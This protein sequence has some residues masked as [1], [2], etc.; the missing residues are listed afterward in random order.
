MR[1][2]LLTAKAQAPRPS[3]GWAEGAHT[4]F[5]LSLNLNQRPG[6]LEP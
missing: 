1:L 4:K 6:S 2:L 5:S 3:Q